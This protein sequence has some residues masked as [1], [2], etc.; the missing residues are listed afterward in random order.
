MNERKPFHG[1]WRFFPEDIPLTSAGVKG[2]AYAQAKTGDMLAGPYS[3]H[4]P[5]TPDDYGST[6]REI[7]NARWQWVT[8]PH[9]YIIHQEYDEK[10]NNSWGFFHHHPAW[11]R[12]HFKLEEADKNKRLVLYFEGVADRCTVYLNGSFMA[13][14]RES[15]TPF[16]VDITD[17]VRFDSEN[18]L[19]I[20]V[21]CGHGEGWWYGGGGI[22]RPVWLEKSDKLAIE[23]YG[24]Y[25]APEKNVDDTWQ[26]PVQ[27]EVR[28]NGI[29]D[30][31][32][33]LTTT[34]YAPTGEA[35]ATLTGEVAVAAREVAIHTYTATVA[36]PALW[37]IDTPNLYTAVTTVAEKGEVY[38]KE[39]TTFGFRTLGF[40]ANEGFFLNGRHVLIKG[41]CGHGDCGLTGRAVPESIY[42]YK[43][44]QIKEMGANAYRCA[45]Y[46]QAEYWMDEM[47]RQGILVMAETR[48]FT[49][50]QSGI[51]ELRT[52]IRRDRNHPSI[53]LWSVGNE[54]PYF[55]RDEGARILRTLKTEARK[56]DKSR[57]IITA[58][59]RTPD[60][61]TVYDDCDLVGVNY[62][63]HMLDMLHEKFPDKAVL[64]TENSATGTTRGWYAEDVPTLGYISAYDHDTNNWF[65]SREKTWRF[66]TDRP[67]MMGGFQWI[68]FEHRGEAT[69]PRLCSAS[70][71][72]DLFMQKKDAFYQNK[73]L[74]DD[75]PVLH[76]LP[77]WNWAHRVG[78]PISVWAYTNAEEV[79]LF[80]NGESQGKV[81]VTA[82]GHAEWQ[83]P[84]VPGTIEAVSYIDGKEVLRDK[85]ETTG[86]AVSL[87]LTAD[88]AEDITANGQDVLLLTCT[89][90]DAQGRTVPDACPGEVLF[91]TNHLGEVIATGSD[92][93]DHTPMQSPRRRMF[94]GAITV[95][96]KLGVTA[97]DLRITAQAEGLETTTLTLPIK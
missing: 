97:G 10:E 51:Q 82:P 39:T 92:N 11:Y 59:D 30:A 3:V 14:S 34:L 55:I 89:C 8:L 83:V 90:V 6:G 87:R 22:Y 66:I 70:G 4:Y 64:S 68:A 75:K 50:T 9:D 79:E 53:F 13:E 61:C 48:F 19:A 25:I 77:H 54:E 17:F 15:H 16:E 18:V 57:P 81:A 80:L 72:I 23:R 20:R 28:N 49:S 41:V 32:A 74:W 29:T 73:S 96:V 38:H 91:Y 43:A 46:P 40:D 88:N 35:V 27:V 63:L 52:L 65:G 12:K 95:A 5:D 71:A 45:H 21:S 42:R 85:Q 33:E 58:N 69:W 76:L 24:V 31:L 26:V 84:Y 37:D 78:E 2:P 47:D 62:N 1:Y 94:A 67:W 36:A 56:L 86:K 93:T 60:I 44:R 7:T